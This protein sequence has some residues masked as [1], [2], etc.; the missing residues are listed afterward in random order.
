MED[1][2][3][4]EIE[5]HVVGLLTILQNSQN[6]FNIEQ[7]E[8]ELYQNIVLQILEFIEECLSKGPKEI[9]MFI[10]IYDILFEIDRKLKLSQIFENNSI[11][12]I[13]YYNLAFCY[14]TLW[15]V[16]N[17]LNSITNSIIEYE[18]GRKAGCLQEGNSFELD[19]LFCQ[20]YLQ[21]AAL[22]SKDKMHEKAL[23]IAMSAV[24]HIGACIEKFEIESLKILSE[25]PDELQKYTKM[26]SELRIF[27][28][29]IKNVEEGEEMSI[30]KTNTSKFLYW[31]HMP[32]N[33]KKMISSIFSSNIDNDSRLNAEWLKNFSVGNIML[34]APINFS[35]FK[36]VTDLNISK[37]NEWAI[38]LTLFLS[39]A[40]FTLAIEKRI[41][42]I[43]DCEI[44]QSASTDDFEIIKTSSSNKM[45][46]EMKINESLKH[47]RDYIERL[48]YKRVLSCQGYRSF[49]SAYQRLS[50]GRNICELVQNKLL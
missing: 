39:T 44:K 1:N 37:I 6:L 26:I 15:D 23:K 35:I 32:E 42:S 5:S 10:K 3:L 48:T 46:T 38:Q 40:C 31:K 29:S 24:Q 45:L 8:K 12:I 41:L 14:Q 36:Q 33:N 49:D 20:V 25:N 28:K 43:R 30:K 16:K 21:G 34:L 27:A 2:K 4:S 19:L 13:L 9:E 17:C 18:M 50:N 7:S 47:N 22:F 11:N